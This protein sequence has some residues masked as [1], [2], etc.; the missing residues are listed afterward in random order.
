MHEHDARVSS[1]TPLSLLEQRERH[2]HR[3]VEVARPEAPPKADGEVK[4]GGEGRGGGSAL[5]SILATIEPFIEPL[6]AFGAFEL[7][8]ELFKMFEAMFEATTPAGA[9]QYMYRQAASE[10][11][12]AHVATSAERSGI[13]RNTNGVRTGAGAAAPVRGGGGGGGGSTD[14]SMDFTTDPFHLGVAA[15]VGA[16][17]VLVLQGMYAACFGSAV[18]RRRE[19]VKVER[20]VLRA[21]QAIAS[22]QSMQSAPP[23]PP[24]QSAQSAQSVAR[25]VARSVKAEQTNSHM[26]PPG[27]QPPVEPTDSMGGVREADGGAGGRP[28]FDDTEDTGSD[29]ASG[30]GQG[31]GQGSAGHEHD[32]HGSA[33]PG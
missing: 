30:S 8:L 3:E 31:Q 20:S 25:S 15:G 23:V 19:R 10:G 22:M 1:V 18:R 13:L 14:L 5:A 12:A 17:V 9:E 28:P 16:L 26:Q 6:R 2:R 27:V 4:G 32:E 29:A 33:A 7:L 21:E 24:V 11:L